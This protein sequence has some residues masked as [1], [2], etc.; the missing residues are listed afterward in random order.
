MSLTDK[1]FGRKELKERIGFLED[2]I[3]SL[4]KEK[5]DLERKAEK[6]KKRAKEAVSEKQD[7]DREIKE[8]KDRIQSLEDKLRK[9]EFLEETT[10]AEVRDERVSRDVLMDLL[11]K[12]ESFRSNKEDLFSVFV[13][14]GSSVSDIDTQGFIQTNLTLNQLRRLKE[15]DSETGKV[16]FHCE[17]LLTFLIKPPVPIDEDIWSKDSGFTVEPLR[18]ALDSSVGFIYLS[19]G[20]SAVALF[21]DGIEDF[22]V[23]RSSIKG[24]HKKGGFS[25]GR[26]NRGREEEV[27]K[28]VEEVVE[29]TETVVPED[30]EVA[31]CGSEDLLGLLRETGFTDRRK[32]FR[33][34][35]DVSGIET[36]D[37]L[38]RAFKKFWRTRIIHL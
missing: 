16:L 28:H 31:V 2:K 6:E 14:T 29:A 11:D 5:K 4:E 34:S 38:D 12:L 26:F 15:E 3:E 13:P 17:G 18:E 10:P 9:K 25:Q 19:A 37:Q 32:T 8:Q 33:R 22:E 35:L 7:L 27:K 21:S 20:G 23:V 36:K 24:K 1:I 30:V